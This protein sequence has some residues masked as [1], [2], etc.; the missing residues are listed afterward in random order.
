MLLTV[1]TFLTNFK[2]H[3]L[4]QSWS[5]WQCDI[6]VLY[7]C[8]SWLINAVEWW[9]FLQFHLASDWSCQNKNIPVIFSLVFT[10]FTGKINLRHA[11]VPVYQD[12]W[13]LCYIQ[14]P[15]LS[16]SRWCKMA[17]WKLLFQQQCLLPSYTA[18][19]RQNILQWLHTYACVLSDTKLSTC[20]FKTHQHKLYI[21]AKLIMYYPIKIVSNHCLTLNN[22]FL[23]TSKGTSINVSRGGVS[24]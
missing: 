6:H 23:R 12:Q 10:G 8:K 21:N 3:Y 24:A 2:P 5:G 17:S 13:S 11:H 7:T 18:K 9:L 20:H 16:V 15:A 19:R 4:L 22:C 14:I 1:L